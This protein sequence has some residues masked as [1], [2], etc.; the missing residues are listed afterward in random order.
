[1]INK[2][3]T[4]LSCFFYLP[5]FFISSPQYSLTH[6]KI[7]YIYY[8]YSTNGSYYQQKHNNNRKF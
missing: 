1:M 3:A 6:F 8:K 5:Q 2:K 7:S 4:Q